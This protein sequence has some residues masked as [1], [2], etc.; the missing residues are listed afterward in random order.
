MKKI[1]FPLAAA[2][3]AA[4][5]FAQNPR[6]P[7]QLDVRLGD[8]QAPAIA[9]EGEL[10]AAVW[11]DNV[12]EQMYASVSTDQGV[13]WSAAVRIDDALAGNKFAEDFGTIVS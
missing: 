12:T 13:S 8:G 6:T 9:T 2:A 4:P 11:K 10:T 5:G 1:L 7:Q 3:L